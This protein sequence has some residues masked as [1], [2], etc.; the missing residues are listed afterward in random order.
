V[1]PEIFVSRLRSIILEEGLSDLSSRYGSADLVGAKNRVWI[2]S[3]IFYKQLDSE[4]KKALHNIVRAE[5]MDAVSTFLAILDG[6]T[7]FDGD[8]TDFTL[9]RGN[10]QVINGD[11]C[12]IFL[13]IEEESG[14]PAFNSNQ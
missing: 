14:N 12:S 10:D 1:H 3:V 7:Y 8:Q 13:A 5:V 6:F 4:Q 11:L 2:E 9:T